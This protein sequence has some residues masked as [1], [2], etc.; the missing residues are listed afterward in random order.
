MHICRRSRTA[1]LACMAL[2]QGNQCACAG[3][4]ST[5]C[6]VVVAGG[7]LSA[8]VRATC[9]TR[10][11][12]SLCLL[13]RELGNSALP[14]TARPE[15]EAVNLLSHAVSTSTA[16]TETSAGTKLRWSMRLLQI[17]LYSR[18]LLKFNLSTLTITVRIVVIGANEVSCHCCRSGTDAVAQIIP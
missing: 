13:H 15:L 9:T 1:L 2:L 11:H 4:L 3:S 7:E 18:D 5:L 6:L 12:P 16:Q 17:L 10:E 8:R 14:A